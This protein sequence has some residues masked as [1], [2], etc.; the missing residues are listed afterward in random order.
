[1]ST[2]LVGGA[3][4]SLI[5]QSQW[6]NSGERVGLAMAM[7]E[8]FVPVSAHTERARPGDGFIPAV[9]PPISRRELP[10]SG[11]FAAVWRAVRKSIAFAIFCRRQ[12]SPPRNCAQPKSASAPSGCSLRPDTFR[13]TDM[14]SRLPSGWR[15][16][17]Q[18]IRDPYAWEKTEHGLARSSRCNAAAVVKAPATFKDIG[19]DRQRNLRAAA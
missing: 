2:S 10:I 7:S 16:L 18:L 9:H 3:A 8:A 1:M 14:R 6:R 19:A 17:F 13:R 11:G 15:A 12:R 4:G 5:A